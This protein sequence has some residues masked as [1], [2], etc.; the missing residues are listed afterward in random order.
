MAEA[1]EE[2]GNNQGR[3]LEPLVSVSIASGGARALMDITEG[4]SRMSTTSCRAD[5]IFSI[6]LSLK[7]QDHLIVL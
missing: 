7:A 4:V 3:P 2:L 5:K 1:L 6:F